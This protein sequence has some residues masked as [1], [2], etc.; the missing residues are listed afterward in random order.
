MCTVTVAVWS[1]MTDTPVG[2]EYATLLVTSLVA[3]ET[4]TGA[5]SAAT[6]ACSCAW[7][8]STETTSGWTSTDPIRN[9]APGVPV[10]IGLTGSVRFSRF[11]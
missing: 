1:P 3:P 10:T 4:G 11:V 7:S 9:P 5:V 8:P 6:R 2:N